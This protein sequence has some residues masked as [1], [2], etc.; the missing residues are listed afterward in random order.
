M[1]E[2]QGSELTPYPGHE[3]TGEISDGAVDHQATPVSPKEYD[4]TREAP[5]GPIPR[6]HIGPV[7]DPR[8]HRD[9]VRMGITTG[10][11]VLLG[12][13]VLGVFVLVG[14]G[15][16]PDAVI[17]SIFTALLAFAGPIIGFYFGSQQTNQRDSIDD[18]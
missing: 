8:P 12:T 7:Y 11:L 17:L 13:C 15:R 16:L 14:L 6:P 18:R 5:G 3:V 9:K 4:L 1:A 2:I 10:L